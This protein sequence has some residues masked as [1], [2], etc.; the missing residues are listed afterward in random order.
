MSARE[1]E[2]LLARLY[3][4]PGYRARFLADPR[5]TACAAGL[6]EAEVRELERIDREGLEL[7]AASYARKRAARK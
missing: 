6:D 1:V 2:I 7:A 3:S 4:D 5:A